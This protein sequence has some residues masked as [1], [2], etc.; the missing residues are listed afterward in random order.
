MGRHVTQRARGPQRGPARAHGNEEFVFVFQ[1]EIALELPREARA[2]AVF[3][4]GGGAHNHSCAGIAIQQRQP[5]CDQRLAYLRQH[6]LVHQVHLHVERVAARL[7]P[8]VCAEHAAR[9]SFEPQRGDLRPVSVRREAETVGNGEPSV[10]ESGEVASF[11]PDAG[12]IRRL[13]RGKRY[14]NIAHGKDGGRGV[15]CS[16]PS[17]VCPPLPT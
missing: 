16:A 6:G 9:R 2:I 15:S 5:R 8:I 12:A 17:V 3:D 11:G 14:D 7:R 1:L 13:R 4:Q 10:P